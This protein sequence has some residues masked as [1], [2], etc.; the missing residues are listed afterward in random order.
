M[1]WAN[2]CIP[3][4]LLRPLSPSVFALVT[5]PGGM[6]DSHKMFIVVETP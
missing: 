4:F 3:R 6:K 1:Q 2:P 5:K